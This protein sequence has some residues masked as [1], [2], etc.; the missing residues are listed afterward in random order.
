MD[1]QADRPQDI[2]LYRQAFR[3]TPDYLYLIDRQGFLVDCNQ[4][5]REALGITAFESQAPGLI[6]QL[7]TDHGFCSQAQSKT[8]KQADI[9]SLVHGSQDCEPQLLPVTKSQNQISYYE[10]QRR[11]LLEQG[12]IVG[13]LVNLKDMTEARTLTEQLDKIKQEL[14]HYNSHENLLYKPVNNQDHA[15]ATPRV[16]LIEDNSIAQK[17][18]RAVLMNSDCLVET[19][20]NETEFE[21][22]F[23]PGKYDLVF[24]DIGLED[25]SG[26]MIAKHLRQKEKDSGQHVPIIALTGF[27]PKVVSVD[28]DYYQMEG[29]LSKPLK[30][31][32]VKQIIQRYLHQIDI[33]VTGLVQVEHKL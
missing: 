27:D 8:L 29:A 7:L 33:P 19:A 25:T 1:K 11:P 5:L 20:A 22:L 16:L 15:I 32:Q 28:C 30:P 4:N 14:Q 23:Q 3:S 31:E 21:T 17:A 6:Y 12:Q 13:L 18:A 10:F 2:G 24:M 26:Y 9:D